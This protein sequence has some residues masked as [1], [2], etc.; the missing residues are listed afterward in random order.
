MS[1]VIPSHDDPVIAANAEIIG[2]PMGKYSRGNPWWSPLRVIVLL[3]ALGYAVGYWLD[4]ACRSTSWASPERYE[5]LCYT[6]I[7]PFFSLK[8]LFEGIFPYLGDAKPEHMVDAPVLVGLF[9]EFSAR[10][11][12]VM[13]GI[14]PSDDQAVQF[15]DVTA[16]LLFLVLLILVITTVNTVSN[17]PWD[18][19]MIA[20]APMMVLAATISW[21]L[22]ALAFVA[23][24]FWTQ[25]KRKNVA[26]GIFLGLALCSASYPI[27][28][29]IAVA[30]I[31]LRSDDWNRIANLIGVTALTWF[32]INLPFAIAN[33]DGWVVIYRHQIETGAEL[34][35]VWFAL[36]QLGGPTLSTPLLNA[37]SVLVF[38]AAVAVVAAITVRALTTPRLAQVAFLLV[39]AFALTAKGFAPQFSLW[40]IPLAVLARPRWRD[41]LIW[42]ACEV[43]YFIAV[44]W[45]LAGYNVEGAKG[46]TPQWYAVAIFVHIAGTLY[47][48]YRV[49]QDIN[50]PEAD[51]VRKT[52]RDQVL[53]QSVML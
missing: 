15:Y 34:G 2:G 47:F 23:L 14:W 51:V 39:A 44:W 10:I 3:T 43:T 11:T 38:L 27:A 20:L 7:H 12:S 48:A 45:F 32:V 22:I 18:A 26:T 4:S 24:A 21:D 28:V 17:R 13:N 33:Y 16:V 6:D 29:V 9:M 41:F 30:V 1:A 42:Q 36:I 50:K 37:A 40:L 53:H 8:G 46:L 49:I 25:S 35:S 19:A 5:H 31:G 52:T